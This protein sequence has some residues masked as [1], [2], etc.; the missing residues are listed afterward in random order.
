MNVEEVVQRQARR[1]G[2]QLISYREVALPLFRVDVDLLVLDRIALPPIQEH[3]LRAADAGL[4][5]VAEIAGFLG[6]EPT[7]VQSSAVEL[8]A[9]DNLML[10][11]GQNGQRGRL[12][13]LTSKGR[14]T[15][16]EAC[17]VQAT[18]TTL[19]V[20]VD[21]LTREVLSVTGKGAQWF[22]AGQISNRG[23]VEIAASPKRRPKDD[24]I[25]LEKVREKIAEE[26]AGRRAK[27]EVIGITG[28]GKARR[29]AREAI[30]LAFEV[31]GEELSI[32]LVVDGEPSEAHDVAF[33]AAL[34]R[35]TRGVRAED[36]REAR[37]LTAQVIPSDLRGQVVSLEKA[38]EIEDERADLRR[39]EERLR[40]IA[41]TA[42]ADEVEELRVEL[43]LAKKRE[44]ALKIELD[45]ISVREVAVYEHRGYL[46]RALDEAKERILIV[47]PWIGFEVVD[48]QLL[49]R[50]RG[51]L[52]RGVEL[53]IGHGFRWERNRGKARKEADRE[54]EKKLG[55][56][57]Q[58]FPD[59]FHFSS[60]GDTHAK[61]LVCDS[62]FSILTSFNWLSFKGDAKLGFRDERGYYVGL[63]D[64]VNELFESYRP[65]FFE[66]PAER[67][68]V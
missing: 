65:R 16:L 33:A 5:E 19:Q 50:F 30:A 28:L 20:W 6:I 42:K 34:A 59:L 43:E 35:S 52:E 58:D 51:V 31:P 38:E 1:S 48:A 10:V 44:E 54:V 12:L 55:L 17:Q 60:F 36:W 27:F 49:K 64:R 53:W 14:R 37:E 29:F 3:V 7:I 62:R 39:E 47:S 24:E 15:V 9:G 18:E 8:L 11:G 40:T 23:L 21:G 2:G 61:V 57:A 68:S 25:T 56:L 26:G 63:E 46:D 4:E 66:S 22:P 45:E 67:S 13:R 32:S 41:R